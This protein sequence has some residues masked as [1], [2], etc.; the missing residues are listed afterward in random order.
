[1]FFDNPSVQHRQG[2]MLE[3]NHYYPFGL[4]MAGISDKALK[5]NYNENK[6]R[7]NGSTELQSK[8]F[9]DGS[10]LEL[11]DANARMY[12]PQIGRF[13]GIDAMA[14]KNNFLSTYQFAGNNPILANDPTGLDQHKDPIQY[15]PTDNLNGQRYGPPSRQ[16]IQ[17]YFNY[18]QQGADAGPDEGDQGEGDAEG[19]GTTDDYSPYWS[20]VIQAVENGDPLPGFT[21]TGTAQYNGYSNL[22]GSGLFIT[23]NWDGLVTESVDES[24]HFIG[25]VNITNYTFNGDRGES[26]GWETSKGA[27]ELTDMGTGYVEYL[28]AE[29]RGAQMIEGGS[30]IKMI[31][32]TAG[33]AA[34]VGLA[35]ISGVFTVIDA[36]QKYGH[37]RNSDKADLG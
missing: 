9:S 12:D 4:S 21:A 36:K 10:G 7:Y 31:S 17:N 2:P 24:Y 16:E 22:S 20:Q 30:E 28:Q 1:M 6:Y 5:P 37:L 34:G 33:R 27:T 14:D 19:D 23:P 11:Y 26:D 13:G 32:E 29:S 35:A 8:E 15:Q 3:E 25:V 18:A